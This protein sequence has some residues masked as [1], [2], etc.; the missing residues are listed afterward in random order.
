MSR[1]NKNQKAKCYFF[2]LNDGFLNSGRQ[3]KIRTGMGIFWHRYEQHKYEQKRSG[4]R[5][6]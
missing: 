2:T 3:R 1:A 6:I 4:T 5:K